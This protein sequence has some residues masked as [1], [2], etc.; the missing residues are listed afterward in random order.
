MQHDAVVYPDPFVFDPERHIERPGKPVQQDPRRTC[1]GFARRIC[2]GM[3]LA[4]TLLYISIVMSLAVFDITN[5]LDE[6][7]N[8]IIPVHKNTSGTIR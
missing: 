3:H 7:G 6:Q 4:E 8:P 2:V 1:F 5:A